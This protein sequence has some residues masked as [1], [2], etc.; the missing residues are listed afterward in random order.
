MYAMIIVTRKHLS[1]TYIYIH[2]QLCVVKSYVFKCA[3]GV[4]VRQIKNVISML[5]QARDVGP[6]LGQ[7]RR[8]LY[9]CHLYI[10]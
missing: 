6:M 8:R 2:T 9:T 5:Q 3:Y 10:L 1:D 4:R 7:H